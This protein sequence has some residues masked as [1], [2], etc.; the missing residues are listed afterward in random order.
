MTPDPVQESAACRRQG[1]TKSGRCVL[2]RTLTTWGMAR[3]LPVAEELIMSSLASRALYHA[4]DQLDG[5][6]RWWEGP[7]MV[8]TLDAKRRL[9][10][11]RTVASAKPGDVFEVDFDAEEDTLVFRRLTKKTDWLAVLTECPVPMDDLP[12]RRREVFRSKL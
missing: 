3:W 5:A 10:V 1:V 9:T 11:P 2:V 8:V 12:P 4:A 6:G 7:T